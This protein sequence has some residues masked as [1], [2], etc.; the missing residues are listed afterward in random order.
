MA[1]HHLGDLVSIGCN[2]QKLGFDINDALFHLDDL[3]LDNANFGRIESFL[4]VELFEK[5]LQHFGVD[6]HNLSRLQKVRARKIDPCG[7]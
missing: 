5:L 1:R 7:P 6:G 3:L 2:H 4:L